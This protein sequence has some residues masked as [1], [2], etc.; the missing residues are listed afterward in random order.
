MVAWTEHY[1]TILQGLE[2]T[3]RLPEDA[4][5]DFVERGVMAPMF[6]LA[7]VVLS[8]P[9]IR[10]SPPPKGASTAA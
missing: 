3:I 9:E 1:K 4:F 6:S 10:E 8:S 5:Q 7:M 2:A